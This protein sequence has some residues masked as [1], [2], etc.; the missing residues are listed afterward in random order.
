MIQLFLFLAQS[1]F[2]AQNFQPSNGPA[3]AGSFVANFQSTGGGAS[4]TFTAAAHAA[5]DAIVIMVLTKCDTATTGVTVTGSGWTWSQIGSLTVN[6]T[7]SPQ[8]CFAAFGAISPNTT[9]TTFTVSWTGGTFS[10]GH[11]AEEIGDEFSHVNTAGG[12]TTFNAVA[13]TDGA[14]GLPS[15]SVTPPNNNEALW[16]AAFGGATAYTAG[17]GFTQGSSDGDGDITEYQLLSGGANVPQTVNF[18]GQS[19]YWVEPA[20]SISGP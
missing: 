15:A 10:A 2:F 18:A 5:N 4:Q 3:Y 19:A 13:L 20:I 1:I 6:T 7:V 11:S 16:G 9:S 14:S 12:T 8:V 17:S